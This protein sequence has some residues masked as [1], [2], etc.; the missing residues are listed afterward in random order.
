MK[1]FRITLCLFL[2][3]TF[4]ISC[5]ADETG[6]GSNTEDF[7]GSLFLEDQ[8]PFNNSLVV[9]STNMSG[10]GWVVLYRDNRNEEPDLDGPVSSAKL[11]QQGYSKDIQLPLLSGL[12]LQEGEVLWAVLH[13]DNGK[14]KVF[15]FK[16]DHRF[17]SPLISNNQIVMAAFHIS[18]PKEPGGSGEVG[19]L[20]WR[21]EFNN[22]QLDSSK[23]N[24]EIF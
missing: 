5:S 15:E 22:G 1:F 10:T 19:S 11:L 17:D 4:F 8:S 3:T 12:E 18:L 24:Y 14:R 13:T 20:I 6:Q 21:D 2:V 7:S 9:K 23:W 16:E